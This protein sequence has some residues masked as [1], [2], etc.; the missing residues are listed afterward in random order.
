MNWNYG[1]TKGSA[2]GILVGFKATT[3]EIVSWQNFKF[4]ATTVVRNLNDKF[5]WR[6]IVVYGSPDEEHK[7]DFLVELDLVMNAS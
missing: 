6:L 4:C 2:G 1:P 5:T 7:L 3:V